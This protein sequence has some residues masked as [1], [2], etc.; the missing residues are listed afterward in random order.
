[1]QTKRLQIRKNIALKKI[2]NN[3]RIHKPYK[4][5]NCVKWTNTMRPR[6]GCFVTNEFSIWSRFHTNLRKTRWTLLLKASESY[7]TA[8][9]LFNSVPYHVTPLQSSRRSKRLK[10]ILKYSKSLKKKKKNKKPVNIIQY[11]FLCSIKSN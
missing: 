11:I 1:M 9:T 6:W 8:H 10:T 4:H 7:S 5:T 2:H 3:A